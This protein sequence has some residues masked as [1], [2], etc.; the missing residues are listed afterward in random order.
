MVNRESVR[1][2][3]CHRRHVA[4]AGAVW[5]TGAND[6]EPPGCRWPYVA[7]HQDKL[8]RILVSIDRAQTEKNCEN[9]CEERR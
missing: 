2:Y 6:K 3:P 8:T 4:A 9:I 5:I 7:G 1:R